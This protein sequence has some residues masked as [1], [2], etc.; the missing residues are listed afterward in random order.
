MKVR[1]GVSVLSGTAFPHRRDLEKFAEL[2]RIIDGSGVEL[3]GTNDTSFIGG[4]AYVRATLIAQIAKNAQVGIHPTNPLTREPQVM[5]AFL[6]SIDAMT[7]GRAFVD[8]GS[9]DS[10]V[11]NIGLVPASRA[12]LEDYITCVRDLI[13][14]GEGSYDGRPQRVRWHGE[15][16]RRRIPITLCAEGPKTLHLGGRICDG[17]IA[18]TGL[19]PEVISD[20]IERVAAGARA[21]GR[22]PSEVEVWFTT[23][24]SLDADRDTAIQRIH[25]S[26][27]SILNHSMRFGLEGKNVPGQLKAK[28]AEYVEGYELYDHVLQA[29]RN[30][31]RMA[32]LGLTEYGLERFALAG[33]VKDW[34]ER[35]GELAEAGA[36]R[37]WLSTESGDLDRQIHY[38]KVFTQ[39]IMPHFR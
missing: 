23:R 9:G 6:A 34:I 5:A 16:V 27:S 13:A 36:S 30:P 14:T 38:M 22:D 2:V 1:F 25:A 11:Y 32:E 10:A 15:A 17:V 7:E 21:A 20:T 37:L 12:R 26:V 3:I 8:I 24:S 19:L 28:V 18:G 29:G 33:N 35:I 39:Q 4:D 31:K